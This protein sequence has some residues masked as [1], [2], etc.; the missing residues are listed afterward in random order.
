ML[1]LV[2]AFLEDRSAVASAARFAR[3]AAHFRSYLTSAAADVKD[4]CFCCGLP[5]RFRVVGHE[6]A[7]APYLSYFGAEGESYVWDPR[8]DRLACADCVP[9]L[10]D[11][12]GCAGHGWEG[13][14]D[15]THSR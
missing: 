7:P 5:L 6:H 15:I 12:R 3:C 9:C 8:T 13:F 1:D 4:A 2:A 10:D 14:C 11:R